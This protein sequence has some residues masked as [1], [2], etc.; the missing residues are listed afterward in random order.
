MSLESAASQYWA[1]S[2]TL[3]RSYW[4]LK[5]LICFRFIGEGSPFQN[6]FGYY[7][8]GVDLT[9]AILPNGWL[10]R[11]ILVSGVNTKKVHEKLTDVVKYDN[12]RKRFVK[13]S[14]FADGGSGGR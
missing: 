8:R 2:P 5:R 10:E 12:V 4:C 13:L 11:L 9:T 1:N 6:V 14:E 3:L 7:S